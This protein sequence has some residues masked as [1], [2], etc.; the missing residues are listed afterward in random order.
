MSALTP[1]RRAELREWAA[2]RGP[3]KVGSRYEWDEPGNRYDIDMLADRDGMEAGDPADIAA[4]LNDIGAL[5]D[6]RDAL[7]AKLAEAQAERDEAIEDGERRVRALARQVVEA[8]QAAKDEHAHCVEQLRAIGQERDTWRDMW[9]GKLRAWRPVPADLAAE[10]AAADAAGCVV[11]GAFE[12]PQAVEITVNRVRHRGGRH[13]L[14]AICW[15][16]KWPEPPKETTSERGAILG[17]EIADEDRAR[18]IQAM[19]DRE[20]RP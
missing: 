12:G 1:E 8:E 13:G 7:A 18:A 9:S 19:R 6:E 20:D 11:L 15:H 4:M 14:R 2:H 17:P 16:P 10:L 3:F 5:L